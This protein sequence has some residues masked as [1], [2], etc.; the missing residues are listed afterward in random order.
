MTI[1]EEARPVVLL[2]PEADSEGLNAFELLGHCDA[3]LEGAGWDQERRLG[4]IR[5]AIAD[6]HEALWR[7]ASEKFD[8]K[9]APMHEE[10][11]MQMLVRGGAMAHIAWRPSVAKGGSHA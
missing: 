1:E 4:W 6:D 10:C 8:L 9:S 3:A 5:E 11:R 7:A 2:P